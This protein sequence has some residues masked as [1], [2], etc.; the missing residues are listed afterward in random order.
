MRYLISISILFGLFGC[1]NF[2]KNLNPISNS[3][4]I[5]A[6][7]IPDFKNTLYK[8]NISILNK[9]L[10]GLLLIKKME[11][12]S[13]RYVFSNEIGIKFFDFKYTNKGVFSVEYIMSQLNKI[14]IINT[15]KTDFE[16]LQMNFSNGKCESF[17]SKVN[18]T[19][20]YLINKIDSIPESYAYIF[21]K[22]D[23]LN[24]KAATIKSKKIIT[25]FCI[26]YSDTNIP[27][28]VAINHHKLNFKINLKQLKR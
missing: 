18:T 16:V 5:S 20:F 17:E 8:V 10:G 14:D 27:D 23:S 21:D 4:E 15:L 9:R 19:E 24:V 6:R 22:I 12:S 1:N 26:I 28:S 13:L 7:Y 3:T 11:D 2:Y 25:S